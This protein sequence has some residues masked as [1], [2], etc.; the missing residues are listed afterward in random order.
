MAIMEIRDL[1]ASVAEKPVLKGLN[2]SLPKG[3]VH[4]IMGPNGVGKSTLSHVLMGNNSFKV[5]GGSVVLDGA[6]LL[7]LDTSERA[8]KGLFLAFQ[9][10][11]SIPGLR[12]S[13]YL[14]NLYNL[15]HGGPVGVSEFRKLLRSRM[16]MLN[17]NR[18]VAS[19]YLNEGFS[20]GEMKRLEMLQLS[21]MQPKVAILD[22][23]D[24]GV[25]IDAQKTIAQAI[26][27]I[28]RTTGT[29]FLIITHYQRLLRFL[30]PHKIHVLM[31][32]TIARS[33]DI[34]IVDSLER[35][36]YDWVRKQVGEGNEAN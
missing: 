10:P 18:D 19:R 12:I 21:L 28:A 29:A 11:V 15:H 6:E 34:S 27:E 24:S 23:I 22:E 17:L 20:G 13:E 7:S 30:N 9:Y 4:I 5:Q 32:G 1:R 26:G 25:D 16:E 31:D 8:R 2:L 35:E 33:G 3:E 36:G 14:R